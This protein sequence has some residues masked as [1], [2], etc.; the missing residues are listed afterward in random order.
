M[1]GFS[2]GLY[3]C[4]LANFAN[5]FFTATLSAEYLLACG[6]AGLLPLAMEP[7]SNLTVP[8]HCKNDMCHSLTI[9][10]VRTNIKVSVIHDII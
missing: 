5:G 6:L 10:Y 1:S 7:L 8:V 4:L 2:S 3:L 9:S